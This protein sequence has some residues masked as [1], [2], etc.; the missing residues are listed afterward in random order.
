[1]AGQAC[2]SI[3]HSASSTAVACAA[4]GGPA[5]AVALWLR[6]RAGAGKSA[7]G[8]LAAAV[9]AFIVVFVVVLQSGLVALTAVAPVLGVIAVEFSLPFTVPPGCLARYQ[10]RA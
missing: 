3:P 9:L 7:L 6:Q 1:M 2:G 8:G 4:V 10:V 5:T